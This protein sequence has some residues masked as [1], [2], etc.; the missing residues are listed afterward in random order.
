MRGKQLSSRSVN[1][2][3]IT[4]LK[5]RAAVY[6]RSKR[7]CM[8]M[9]LLPCAITNEMLVFEEKLTKGQSRF[10]KSLKWPLKVYETKAVISRLRN[11]K[12]F[13]NTAIARDSL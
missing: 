10:K 6:L 2:H 3:D 9:L 7:C 1:R 8:L 12:S 13:L 11:L 4:C 5:R